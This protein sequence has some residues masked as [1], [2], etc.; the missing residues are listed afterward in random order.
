MPDERCWVGS[1]TLLGDSSDLVGTRGVNQQCELIERLIDVFFGLA[2]AD[3]TH[4][5]DAFPEA[6]VDQTPLF[7]AV[8]SE[9]AAVGLVRGLV[10]ITHNGGPQRLQT[11]TGPARRWRHEPLDR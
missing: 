6:P 11:V 7:T 5:H 1:V 9:G 4:Q 2:I 8:I 10:G 3:D